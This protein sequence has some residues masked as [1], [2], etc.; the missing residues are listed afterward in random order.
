MNYGRMAVAA[1]CGFVA[2][3]VLGG[4]IFGAIPSLKAEFQKYP[5]VYR[6][7]Q[8]QLSHMPAGMLGMFLAVAVLSVLYAM[9]YRPGSGVRNGALFGALIGLFFLGSFVLH[10]YVNL[11]IDL[12]LTLFSAAAFMLEWTVVGA[13]LGL[14]YRP[15]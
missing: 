6:S 11:N 3:M 4:L 10:N 1:V 13:V 12:R 9:V 5:N 15:K 8:G 7:Q 14:I 2:Y